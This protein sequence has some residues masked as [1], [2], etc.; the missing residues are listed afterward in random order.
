[1]LKNIVVLFFSSLVFALLWF[2]GLEKVYAQLLVFFT[3]VILG[4]LSLNTSMV[5]MVQES[6]LVII[7]TTI[8]NGSEG[9]FPQNLQSLLLP[10]V[11]L[12]SWFPVLFIHLKK[13][14]A[15]HQS[16]KNAGLFLLIQLFFM[17]IL[18][19]FYH[20]AL[21]RYLF[22]LLIEAFYIFA[23]AVIIKD[24]LKYPFIWRKS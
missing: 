8:L 16:L 1:M 23:I 12:L 18:A 14:T 21:S 9:S 2:L 15:I 6:E 7:V 19:S 24:S 10:T 17:L 11:I 20:F 3:N 13:R 5:L 4:I 22:Y